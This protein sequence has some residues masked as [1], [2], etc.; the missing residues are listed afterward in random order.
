MFTRFKRGALACAL[1]VSSTLAMPASVST[2]TPPNL[3]GS[4][5]GTIPGHASVSSRGA[6]QY[7]FPFAIPPGTAGMAP[8]LG[9]S[10]DSENPIDLSGVGWGLTGIST[11][12]RCKRT[13]A[14]DNLVHPVD[15]TV[16]D[17]YCLNGERLIKISGTDG[18]AAE[19]RTEVE[20]FQRVK[21][22]GS[23][24]NVGPDYWT[25]ETRDG[26]VLT[27]GGAQNAT[28]SV[29]KGTAVNWLWLVQRVQDQHGNFMTYSYEAS[30][31]GERFPTLI[32]YTGNSAAGLV[33]YNSVEFVYEARSD[34]FSGRVSDVLI[35]RPN[36]LK[37][38]RTHIGVAA[39]GSG[40]AIARQWNLAY[41]YSAYSNRSLLQSVTD[42]NGDASQCLPS[43]TFAW[44]QRD[45]S[46][47]HLAGYWIGHLA[48]AWHPASGC[49]QRWGGVVSVFFAISR[50]CSHG[51]F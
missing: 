34:V 25:V 20:S 43:T 46:K 11:I 16:A 49:L 19:Y 40:G 18:A 5:A 7:A 47:N 4:L 3:T 32:L 10:Y 28:V 50:T 1:L 48:W 31:N 29:T 36:R 6:S 41:A 2:V 39:D 30:S 35:Q 13:L 8:S 51:R 37:Q 17:A 42:C 15:L 44:T 9:L 38:V 27:I 22:F 45:T 24:T 23:N 33:P 21:S 14:T 12:T 26:R